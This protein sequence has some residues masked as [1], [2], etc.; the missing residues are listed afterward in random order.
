M[1]SQEEI[2]RL[3]DAID[4]DRVLRARAADP[5]EKF[6]DGL[7]LF[8]S[9]LEFT[10]AGVAAELGTQD[11]EAISEGVQRRFQLIR[12]LEEHGLYHPLTQRP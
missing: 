9:A 11:E 2:D 1:E 3:A 12:K 6:L 10:R 5:A 8:E 4:R 7:R